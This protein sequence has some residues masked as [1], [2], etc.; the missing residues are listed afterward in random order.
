M[1]EVRPSPPQQC[2]WF[3]QLKIPCG[4]TAYVKGTVNDPTPF[5]ESNK[6]HGSIHWTFERALSAALIPVTAATAV[7]SAN[8]V[9]DGILGV[10]LIFH[11]HLVRLSSCEC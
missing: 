8:P 2:L 1:Q 7:V 3:P 5:P 4:F 11:S 10:A 9:L 6:A